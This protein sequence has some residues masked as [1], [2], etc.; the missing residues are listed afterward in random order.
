MAGVWLVRFKPCE[1]PLDV[2]KSA[3]VQPPQPPDF[4]LKGLHTSHIMC[5]PDSVVTCIRTAH[6]NDRTTVEWRRYMRDSCWKRTATH[7]HQG[8]LAAATSAC[9]LTAATT[10][11]SAHPQH[12]SLKGAALTMLIPCFLKVLALNT[13]LHEQWWCKGT[14]PV[15]SVIHSVNH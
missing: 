2:T 3:L 12:Q 9:F 13:V 15:H 11:A 14:G 6:S 1:H 5:N 10:S 8:S 4:R 7:I